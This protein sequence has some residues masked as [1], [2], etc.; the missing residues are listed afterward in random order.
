MERD[1]YKKQFL[2]R[3]FVGLTPAQKHATIGLAYNILRCLPQGKPL[4]RN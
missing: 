2:Y 1:A 4:I 3:F